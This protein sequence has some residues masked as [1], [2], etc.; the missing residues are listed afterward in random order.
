[1]Y[2]PPPPP[3]N[4]G[5]HIETAQSLPGLRFTK[6]KN[7]Q[8]VNWPTW[9]WS[10]YCHA[11]NYFHVFTLNSQSWFNWLPEYLPMC[12]QILSVY[13]Q[14][15]HVWIRIATIL[16]CRLLIYSPHMNPDKVTTSA[17]WYIFPFSLLID[18]FYLANTL[19]SCVEEK[20]WYIEIMKEEIYVYNRLFL[21]MRI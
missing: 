18:I 6:H 12:A 1:M 8:Q 16:I 15:Y 14:L 3:L 5:T 21:H 2:P 10:R 13:N 17:I 19:N 7:A 20:V 4:C 9:I 11:A